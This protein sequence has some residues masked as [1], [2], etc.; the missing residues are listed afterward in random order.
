M[1]RTSAASVLCA[2]ALAAA[3][4]AAAG[5]TS[6]SY[7]GNGSANRAITGLGFR[8]D[9]VVVKADS[10]LVRAVVRTATMG[11]S[12]EMT[13]AA[14][15]ATGYV[16][17]LD[18]D[19]FTVGNN[20]RVNQ[21]GLTYYWIAFQ[22]TAGESR[23]GNYTG[24]GL[25]NRSITGLGFTPSYVIVIPESIYPVYQRSSPMLESYSFDSTTGQTN[26]V[27]GMV[28][29]GFQIGNDYDVNHS[30]YVYHYVAWKAVA[31]RMAVGS[32]V[33]LG[34]DN[35]AI[36][37]VGFR[38]AY[39]VVKADDNYSAAHKPVSTGPSTDATLLFS[40]IANEADNI[41]ELQ[42]DGFEVGRAARV[43]SFNR[44]VYWMA[45]GAS[46][47]H[48]SVSRSASTITVET[49]AVK[50][51]WD[52]AKG[53]G[54]HQFY[55]KTEANPATSRVGSDASYSLFAAGVN[56]VQEA[57]ALGPLELLEATATRAR[58]RQ[59][60][61]FVP[62]PSG[63]HLERDWTVY[64][65]PRLG[66][67]E[68]LAFDVSLAVQGFT[69]L[70]TKGQATCF[71][72]N[73]FYCA[74]RSDAGN[75]VWLATD[76]QTTYSDALAISWTSPFFGRGGTTPS[77]DNMLEAGSPNSWVARVR[78]TSAA[79]AS[80]TDT[81]FYLLYPHVEG[82]TS[83]GTEWQPYANDYRGPSPLAIAQGSPWSDAAE[84]TAPG[85]AFNEA[86]A[87]YVLDIDPVTGLD[88]S[89]DG[90]TT[91]PRLRPFFKIRQWRSLQEPATVVLQGTALVNDRD[92]TA[93]VKP[94]AYAAFCPDPA[95]TTST[96]LARGGL[97][98]D[99]DEYLADAARDQLLGF[100]GA[101]VQ[102]LYLGTD[103]KFRGLNVALA[104]AG[105]GSAD[106]KWEYFNGSAWA[107]LEA[108]GG[109]TDL[110]G[111]LT[112]D[113]AIFW[114]ADPAG[115]SLT[116]PF[117]GWPSLYY[118]RASLSSGSYGTYPTESQIR[119]DILLFQYLGSLTAAGRRFVL[120]PGSSNTRYRSIGTRADYGTAGAEGS[121][122][123]VTATSGS[124]LVTG[125]AGTTW[126]AA[127]RG[128][129]D[130][131][132][133]D[134]VDYTV[135][136]VTAEG[137]LELTEAYAGASGSGKTYAIARKFATLVAW[138]DCI[139][140]PGGAGCEGV[141][142]ASLVADNRSEVGVAY[143]DT[144]FAGGLTI[145]GS[146]TD[147]SHTITL[148]ADHGNRHYGRAGVAGTV[149]LVDNATAGPAIRVRDDYVTVEWLEIRGGSG[150]SAHGVE[151]SNLATVN[152]VVLDALLVHDTPGSGIEILH[153]DALV[154]AYNDVIYE[155]G[156]GIRINATPSGTSQIRLLNNT[157]YSCNSAGPSGILSTAASNVAVTL[158]N[159]IAHGNYQGDF[160]VPARNGASS[161]NLSS[162][163]TGPAHSPGGGGL[164][165]VS[166]AAI[167]VS[168]A[169]PDLHLLPTSPA[170][171]VGADLGAIFTGDVDAGIRTGTWD[172]G[173]D[174]LPVGATDVTV[175]KDDGQGTAV[176]GGSVVYTIT[177]KNNGPTTVSSLSLVDVTPPTLLAPAF[178]VPSRGAYNSGTGAWDFSAPGL[179]VGD[180][181]TIQL[182][183][184]IDPAASGTL[185]NT[186][187]VQPLLPL[188]LVDPLPQNNAATDTDVLAP[189]AD[190]A[191]AH[192]DAPDPVDL[193][194][195][196]TYT[197]TVTNNGPSG[198]T[199]V[200]LTDVLPAE[201]EF[202]TVT[203]SQGVCGFD[204]PM[205]TLTC[206]LGGLLPGTATV[207]LTVRPRGLG[208]FTATAS[209]VR[210]EP[211]PAP[212]ND[213]AL[214]TTTVQAST[215]AV[216]FLTVTSTGGR[217]VIEWLNP[218]DAAYSSTEIRVRTDT[219]PTSVTDGAWVCTQSAPGARDS[220]THGSLTNG[221]TY[222]YAAY[223]HRSAAPLVSPG[224]FVRGRPFFSAA[225][226]PVKWAFSTGGFSVTPPTVGGAGV[227]ATSNDLAVHAMARGPAGGEWPRGATTAD[228]WHPYQVGG[229]VQSRSPVVPITFGGANPVLFLGSQDG[230]VYAL[231]AV[232]G[233]NAAP[234]WVPSLAS[235]GKVV[236]AAPAGLFI[237]FGGAY[238]YLLVGTRDGT[239][240]NVFAALDPGTGAV[241]ASFDDGG[242]P[243]NGIGII[244][245]MAAVDYASPPR[246]FFTS[247]AKAGGSP[248]NL[249]CLQLTTTP[250][251]F[252]GCT[253]WLGRADLGDIDASPVLRGGR[254]YVGGVASG[255]TVYSIDAA[256]GNPTYDRTFVHGD[257]QVKGFV[258]P[259]RNSG[260]IYFATD[261]YVWSLSDTGA[262]TMTNNF[263]SGLRLGTGVKP[264][265]VLFVPGST[266]VYAGGSDGKLYEIDVAGAPDVKA[267]PLGD[268]VS[269]VGAPSLDRDYGLLHVGTEAGVFYA[270]E[271]PFPMC[272]ASCTGQI[273]GTPCS[274]FG[275][276]P[277]TATCLSN[278]CQ[279]GGGC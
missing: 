39:V 79:P 161:N 106:L 191:L 224:R 248:G 269:V 201:M 223:V 162:D 266:Y 205:R 199:G 235:G 257:G 190:L 24:N 69:G 85:D 227:I 200:V 135:A 145:D 44:H 247:H 222:Y 192:A 2:L 94:V 100:S 48:L 88:F 243:G 177:V 97:V 140:G 75:R 102:H 95:C 90:S 253:G 70:H 270:V 251:V 219:Y 77:W 250:S 150:A 172:V 165:V 154:D 32:Y 87:A 206:D 221:Q 91:A 238:D 239:A 54:L 176:P 68:T 207:T 28:A 84:N 196:L 185:A 184:T 195:I 240:D 167:F 151:V 110:T 260:D 171:D 89:I 86:E 99:V 29:D 137:Q 26:H 275:A 188:G 272:T 81:R 156:Y 11:L 204:G 126:L 139:D 159:N 112:R 58:I 67:R 66:I 194:G 155:A 131:V 109:F 1:A 228:D 35:R 273:D 49:P 164:Q 20:S 73:T 254:I 93:D 14:A 22:T 142:S 136:A 179:G 160:G 63:V 252:T 76:N 108:V 186:V 234:P 230:Y 129:G 178:S 80:G 265:T 279:D 134:G 215:I 71:A 3:A 62:S 147:A 38:P 4:T 268:G 111:S 202:D 170:V 229:P 21:S 183:A 263:A 59:K 13:G 83:T 249:W 98:G 116:A 57:A 210:N 60:R 138:E 47:D 122:T 144:P 212:G 43:N 42:A 267:V 72:A 53:G 55:A 56:G 127:N 65:A 50:M 244:S 143:R 193:G 15:A 121:G 261:N 274:C 9:V 119:T 6:G 173:A 113:G 245:S 123:T 271:E 209:V 104:T 34:N 152:H 258:F 168:V 103:S 174:E 101:G 277:C 157:V 133:I 203:P 36:T 125:S 233:G 146:T 181:A 149:A 64:A 208:T 264:S 214:A 25:D 141:S 17:S 18:A 187:T 114:D 30:G 124:T 237:G 41:Q 262:P 216:R 82:L 128:R 276:Y 23:T 78:E 105:S 169:A 31:G 236:Q 19:G 220:Y 33:G 37:G 118:V 10:S 132:Q 130:R 46:D 256:T 163:A 242:G 180:T 231:D 182:L 51:V 232:R 225:P 197:L 217:N 27:Q 7:V 74:G 45:W 255:G 226:W 96:R 12:K 92:F 117:G 153:P 241:L 218:I 8:P 148:T 246:V 120:S 259:D 115:W 211:D 5:V 40:L 198:A 166:A 16:L 278:L 175:T 107:D 52:E 61:D 189:S 213:T 158:R